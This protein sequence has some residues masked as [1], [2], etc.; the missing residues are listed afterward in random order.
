MARALAFV[1]A[2]IRFS[3]E[4]MVRTALVWGCGLA[5]ILAPFTAA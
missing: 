2:P 4:E 5:L 3:G 1:A